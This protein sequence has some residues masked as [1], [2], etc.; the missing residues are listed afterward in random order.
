MKFPKPIKKPKKTMKD[1]IKTR[2]LLKLK[3]KSKGVK[4]KKVKLPK[5]K[6][7]SKLIKEEREILK[8]EFQKKGITSCELRFKNCWKTNAL[9]FSHKHKRNWYLG[10]N[11]K[12][13][14]WEFNQVIL[15]CNSCHFI[16]EYDKELTKKVFKKLR[17]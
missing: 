1:Y 2:K 13:L 17:P 10:K 15:A 3:S 14:L 11:N 4:V 12:E 6:T 7:R 16:I 8:K 9:G 5:E